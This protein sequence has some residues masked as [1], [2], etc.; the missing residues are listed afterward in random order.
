MY[1]TNGGLIMFLILTSCSS[2]IQVQEIPSTANV[3]QEFQSFAMD[4]SI[5]ANNQANVLSPKNFKEAERSLN[6]ARLSLEKQKDPKDTL[7]EIATGRAYLKQANTVEALSHTNMEEVVIARQR[8]IAAGAPAFF[9]TAFQ[10]AD[11]HLRA[12]T[13]DLEKNN[14]KSLLK[15]RESLQALYMQLELT[16]IKQEKLGFAKKSIKEAVKNDAKKYAPQTLAIAE[17]NYKDTEAFITANRQDMEE[18]NTRTALLNQSVDR[19]LKITQASLNTKKVSPEEIALQMEKKQKD[20]INEKNINQSLTQEKIS[21]LT[22]VAEKKSDLMVEQSVSHSLAVENRVLEDKIA[23]KTINDKIEN[24]RNEFTNSEAE[25][26]K[27]G[28]SL[29]IR[30]RGLKFPSS[31]ASLNGS[32]FN[33]L[34]KVQKVIKE[35]DSSAVVVEGHTDS[36]GS[37]TINTKISQDRA[38]AVRDYFISNGI[39]PEDK[40]QAIGYGEKIP[41]SSNKT[42]TGRA[43]NRRVDIVIKLD[44]PLKL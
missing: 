35:F 4:M 36:V 26:Y 14:F 40:I 43:D 10:K 38:Q 13:V 29:T 15:N 25:I 12:V 31:K 30:L 3:T 34:G 20:L 32:D 22:E 41:L 18:V 9:P 27:Q 23:E 16:A 39:I 44:E 42:A 7:H 33:L 17:K 1:I 37:R 19:L 5:S 6:N 11:D 2:G 8:A 21:L 24:A 28:N